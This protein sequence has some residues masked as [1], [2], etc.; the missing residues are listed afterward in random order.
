[1]PCRSGCGLNKIQTG[2]NKRL[3]FSFRACHLCG[4]YSKPLVWRIS[5]YAS[6][7]RVQLVTS[8]SCRSF[9]FSCCLMLCC[10]GRSPEPLDRLVRVII[11]PSYSNQ[12]SKSRLSR[13]FSPS[14]ATKWSNSCALMVIACE[15][16]FEAL[17]THAA[18]PC[19]ADR[20]PYPA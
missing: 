12:A 17:P 4:A 7:V 3:D 20:V 11:F 14:L 1:M 9:S 13:V 16:S 5:I 10:I 19:L 15:S 8:L 6:R 2:E 18:N